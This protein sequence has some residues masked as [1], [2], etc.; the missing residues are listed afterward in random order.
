MS[1]K[2]R[3]LVTRFEPHASLLT[4]QLNSIGCF[5][6][7]QPLLTVNSMSD[8]SMVSSITSGDFDIIIAIS[9]N[10]VKFANQQM[11]DD[12]PDAT[13]VAVGQSTRK[14]LMD[15][16]GQPV[17]CPESRFDSEGVLALDA[18]KQINSKRILIICGKGGRDLLEMKLA[19]RGA[20]VDLFQVYKRIKIDL[21]G[22]ELVNNWQQGA[23]NGVIISSIEIL[24]QLFTLVPSKDVKWL[25]GLTLYVPSQ[26]VANHA[27]KL[28]AQHVV[29]LPSL[30]TEEVTEFFNLGN[31]HSV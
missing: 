21:N 4:S 1:L 20:I 7:A 14:Q 8:S 11:S 18:L 9:G 23:I 3:L 30:K 15:V 13:Y 29:L 28:G 19:E 27:Y 2:P 24:S 5:A 26:R 22:H 31:G 16:T 6:I 10:A 12:W 25:L 17:L